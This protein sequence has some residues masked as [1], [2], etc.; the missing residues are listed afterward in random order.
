[1]ILDYV[2]L[3]EIK[4]AISGYLTESHALLTRE[5]FPDEEAVHD[6]R[7]LMKRTRAALKLLRVQSDE[8]TFSKEYNSGREV[9]R[10][11]STLRDQSVYRKS[12]KSLKKGHAE[13]FERLGGNKLIKELT[14]NAQAPV[15]QEHGEVLTRVDELLK[16]AIYRMRFITLTNSDPHLLIKEL[17][18]TYLSTA[19][20]YIRCRNTLNP[21]HIHDFRKRTKDFLYQLSFFRPLNPRAI[22]NLEKSLEEIAQYLGRYNDLTQLVTRLEYSYKAEGNTPETDELII[23]IKNRQDHYLLEVWPTAYKIF[24]PGQKLVNLLGF[25]LLVI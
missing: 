1:M 22:K 14:D 23:V 25:K 24:C 8:E 10:L 18:K 20:S 11:L 16:K 13:L 5:E 6:I 2:K 3:K 4:P 9:G 17:E 21:V 12:L 7:V 15:V 19:K